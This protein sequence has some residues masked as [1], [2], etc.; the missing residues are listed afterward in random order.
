ML[1]A[2]TEARTLP[3]TCG[4]CA[5]HVLPEAPS[6]NLPIPAAPW[7]TGTSFLLEGACYASVPASALRDAEEKHFRGLKC[8]LLCG[9]PRRWA[10]GGVSLLWHPRAGSCCGCLH[11]SLGFLTGKYV[12][13]PLKSC[14]ETLRREVKAI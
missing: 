9:L 10:C 13:R 7:N 3:G 14:L 12:K 5:G 1:I 4:A 6:E 11:F 2:R 8:R